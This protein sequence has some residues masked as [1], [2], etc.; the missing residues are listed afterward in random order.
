MT[1]FEKLIPENR[2]II[3]MSLYPGKTREDVE[4]ILWTALKKRMRLVLV[5]SIGIIILFFLAEKTRQEKKSD[6]YIIERS[7]VNGPEKLVGININ[8][9][10][11]VEKEMLT[12]A[13]YEMTET[14]INNMHMEI[15]NELDKV[16]LGKNEGFDNIMW[17]MVLPTELPGYPAVIDWTSDKSELLSAYGIVSNQDLDHPTNVLIKGK[18][19][20]G[21]EY[22][23]Y[24]KTVTVLP[25]SRDEKEQAVYDGIREIRNIEQNGRNEKQFVIPE[26]LD[27]MTIS[28]QGS[29]EA[30]IIGLG[31]ILAAIVTI[32]S[33]SEFFS[34]MSAKRKRRMEVAGNDY[35]EFV[36]K[37]SLLLSAGMTLRVAW[38]KLAGD[39]GKGESKKKMLSQ[40]LAVSVRELENGEL[41]QSVYDRFGERMENIAYQRLVQIMNQQITKG[42][43]NLASTLNTELK[44]VIAK[45]KE[46]IRIRGEE[47]GTKLLMPMMGILIIVFG[48][49]LLPAFTSF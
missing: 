16:V 7:D 42:V 34:S 6:P 19:S 25:C 26:T 23:I 47:A 5:L 44:D 2:V 1:V 20:Y 3:A 43:S 40:N 22:R 36:S 31:I 15:C 12:I 33:Y 45:E 10:G 38:K 28:L 46:N 32:Y 27:G 11:H 29:G 8:S 24:E 30:S 4:K 39:Y 49:L 14:Q 35:K 17:D 9:D 37:L 18:V 48:I 13:P 21:A 41:E